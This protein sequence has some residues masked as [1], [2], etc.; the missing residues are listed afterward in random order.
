MMKT[1]IAYQPLLRDEV[2]TVR[3]NQIS[4]REHRLTLGLTRRRILQSADARIVVKNTRR[5][6][7]SDQ[8]FGTLVLSEADFRRYAP[9][10]INPFN[11]LFEIRRWAIARFG[12]TV[13]VER[14]G[15]RYLVELS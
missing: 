9:S 8:Q 15:R 1:P 2:E 10:W 3:R 11:E 12:G 6:G 4:I 14:S 13:S 7:P 5:H